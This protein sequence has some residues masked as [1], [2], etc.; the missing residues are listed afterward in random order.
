L[1]TLAEF[2]AWAKTKPGGV[3]FS[4]VGFGTA[5]HLSA[6][7]FRSSAGLQTLHVPFRGGGEAMTEVIAGRIDFF[8]GPVGLVLPLVNDRQLTALAVN[9][10]VRSRALPHVPTMT[11]AGVSNAEYPF[12]I[13][14]FLPAKTPDEIA[15]KL[16]DETAK[17]LQVPKVR[18]KLAALGVEPM[19]M[20]PQEFGSYVERA[21]ASDEALV[22]AA[23]LKAQ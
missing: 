15:R 16:H 12:W 18:D 10:D 17:A 19:V 13:G 8:V 5:T 23:N 9:T 2:L 20:T 6:E 14:L 7:R 3:T 11:E 1:T 21:I 22:R 4:S